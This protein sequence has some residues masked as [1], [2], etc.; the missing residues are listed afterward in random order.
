M[1]FLQAYLERRYMHRLED[2]VALAEHYE[3]ARNDSHRQ[4]ALASL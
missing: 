3:E 4:V 2:F 1:V